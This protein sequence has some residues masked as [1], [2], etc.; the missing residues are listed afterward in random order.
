MIN[1]LLIYPSTFPLVSYIVEFSK[2]VLTEPVKVFLHCSLFCFTLFNLI[3]CVINCSQN[4]SIV[5]LLKIN[6]LQSNQLVTDLFIDASGVQR[7]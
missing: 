1:V 6:C 2:V 5:G 3:F 7:I 4:S